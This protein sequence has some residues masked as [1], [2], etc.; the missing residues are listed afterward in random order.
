MSKQASRLL[1]EIPCL[2]RRHRK[3]NQRRPR[4]KSQRQ[5]QRQ[6]SSKPKTRY[7]PRK[8]KMLRHRSQVIPRYAGKTPWILV[9]R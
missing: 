1:F 8:R 7:L 5:R 4:F 9:L 3:Q 6:Y 2:I